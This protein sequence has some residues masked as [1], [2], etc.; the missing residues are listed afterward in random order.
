MFQD[1]QARVDLRG[2]ARFGVIVL[3]ASTLCASTVY[4]AHRYSSYLDSLAPLEEEVEE[5]IVVEF[6]PP[7]EP[8][9]EPE[10]EPI[11]EPPPAAAFRPAAPRPVI[12]PPDEIPD[13]R[14][15]ES[16]A[17]LSEARD[18]GPVGGDTRGTPGGT[19][20][21]PA[22]A[23]EVA[24]P[25][26]EPPPVERR[27]P[28]TSTEDIIRPR[29]IGGPR[30]PEMPLA[31]RQQGVQGVVIL[32][33]EIDENGTLRRYN[34]IRGPEVFHDAVRTWIRAVRFSAAQLPDGTTIPYR[35][36]LPVPFRLRN[37]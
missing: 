19:G 23:P 26:P 21:R 5:E 3:L 4:A 15:E 36:Q 28:R 8:E 34:I 30:A 22:P 27:R 14:P 20:T 33:L 32:M 6:A 2:R 25:P 9:P 13:E 18:T 16:D 7:P 12:R 10:V 31:A 1:F 11:V 29:I 24:P 35:I 37:L 17:E